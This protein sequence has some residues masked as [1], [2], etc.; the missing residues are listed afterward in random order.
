MDLLSLWLLFLLFFAIIGTSFLSLLF[1]L[2]AWLILQILYLKINS[3][4]ILIVVI[5]ASIVV[6]IMRYERDKK[7]VHYL[8]SHYPKLFPKKV[9]LADSRRWRLLSHIHN[10]VY[11]MRWCTMFVSWSSFPDMVL[12]RIVRTRLNLWQRLTSYILGKIAAYGLI[13]DMI[14]IMK[15]WWNIHLIIV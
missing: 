9:N 1:P 3:L 11:I 10:N 2:T 8:T 13:L 7:I 4:V 5:L 12:I 15:K 14:L 6:W